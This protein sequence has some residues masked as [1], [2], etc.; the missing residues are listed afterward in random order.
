ML[1]C[2]ERR[3]GALVQVSVREGAASATGDPA[4]PLFAS[5]VASFIAVQAPDAGVVG[6]TVIHG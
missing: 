3:C 4:A 2:I 1:N 6:Q 5:L